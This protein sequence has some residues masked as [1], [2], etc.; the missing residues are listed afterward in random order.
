[1]SF[2]DCGNFLHGT[3]I[4]A[5][6]EPVFVHVTPI[7]SILP[8]IIAAP[9]RDDSSYA[10]STNT[11][12]NLA[13]R[14]QSVTASLNQQK[15]GSYTSG[16]PKF[17]ASQGKLQLSALT[18]NHGTGSVILQT[19]SSAGRITQEMLTRLPTSSTLEKSY[20]NLVPTNEHKN[21]RLV[22]N[23]AVQDSYS[24]YKKPDFCLPAIIDRANE[25]IPVQT[26]TP[27][28]RISHTTVPAKRDI[29]HMDD[30]YSQ[31]NIIAK[32]KI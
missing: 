19:V 1:M 15:T 6:R 30:D 12:P 4:D 10:V 18:Q 27:K 28:Q 21:L 9:E 29:E 3:K 14:E 2:S 13:G 7:I 20:S 16:V 25:S 11:N 26:Y 5:H 24:L 22:L 31:T 8:E 17:S 23:M 32:K